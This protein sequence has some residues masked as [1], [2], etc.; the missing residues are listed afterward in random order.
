MHVLETADR[1]GITSRQIFVNL[2]F[3]HLSSCILSHTPQWGAIH[4]FM[5]AV[6]ILV[7][8]NQNE[9]ICTGYRLMFLRILN[10]LIK[11]RKF[12]N[13]S[14]VACD[15]GC[16]NGTSDFTSSSSS[17]SSSSAS[18]FSSSFRLWSREIQTGAAL[19]QLILALVMAVSSFVFRN[20][21]PAPFL[22]LGEL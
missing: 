10:H 1:F 22:S 6:I 19:L 20:G 11:S 12:E 18:L 16:F 2:C 9:E 14:A 17:I 4:F 13:I 21:R 15:L 7:S 3:C 5:C 8:E